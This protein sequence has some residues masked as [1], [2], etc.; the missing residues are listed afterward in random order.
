MTLPEV[1][2][3]AEWLAARKE[4][5][6]REKELTRARDRLN[7][8][9]RR[10][11]MVRVEKLYVFTGPTGAAGLLDLF[12][13]R[14]QLVVHHFM[15]A[16]EWEH[17]CPSCSSAADGIAGPRQLHARR[18][19]APA[20]RCSTRTPRSGAGSRSS[21]TATRTSISPRSAGRRNGRNRAAGPSRSDGRRAVP[22][23]GSR[24]ITPI[25][26]G[27][28]CVLHDLVLASPSG[29][30][31]LEMVRLC[32]AGRE[33]SAVSE[34]LSL[35]VMD[36]VSLVRVAGDLDLELLPALREVLQEALE[37]HPWVIVDLSGAGILE[38]VGLSPLLVACQAARR[39][40]GDL[41]LANPAPIVRTVLRAARLQEMFPV[42]D[43]VPQAM[44]AA[45]A[46]VREREA[47][48][49]AV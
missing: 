20:T 6:R 16:P 11:P 24:T 25:D 29:R 23:C 37:P 10:L 12:A 22:G 48:T 49:I 47:A 45:F 21:T 9:R 19:T 5:L 15:F 46:A 27:L 38:S 30:V 43:T 3:R 34:R 42:H 13:G 18:T 39:E 44:T 4:L 31:T 41:L 36:G 40:G 2:T 35:Q 33:G 26:H 1:V 8:D 14:E 7:A 28:S 17:A 32:G